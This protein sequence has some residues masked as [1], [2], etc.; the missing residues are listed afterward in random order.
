VYA[1]STRLFKLT[2]FLRDRDATRAVERVSEQTRGWSG[3][4]SVGHCIG[5]LCREL[6][7]RGHQK[8]MVVVIFSDGWDRGDPAVLR[9]EIV[10]LKNSVKRLVWLNPLKAD[11]AY[12]PLSRGMATVLPYLDSFHAA[13]SVET[14]VAVARELTKIR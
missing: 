6:K 14:L 1:F 2:E 12:R 3:G 9:R 5:E 4:T 8:E 7:F 13:N 11:P 10:R